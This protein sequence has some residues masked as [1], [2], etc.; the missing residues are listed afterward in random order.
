MKNPSIKE[1]QEPT[2]MYRTFSGKT[3]LVKPDN[4]NKISSFGQR[5][6]AAMLVL[7]GKACASKWYQMSYL[8]S[9]KF[10]K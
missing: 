2:I 8:S 1:T 5:L 10:K 6:H 4:F 7:S 3:Y 9:I